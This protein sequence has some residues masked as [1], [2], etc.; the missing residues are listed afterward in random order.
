MKVYHA[1]TK[2][3]FENIKRDGFIQARYPS[4]IVGYKIKDVKNKKLRSFLI[5]ALSC[6]ESKKRVVWLSS[7]GIKLNPFKDEYII[8]IQISEKD[9][10][11]YVKNASSLA[12]ILHQCWGVIFCSKT[13][14][15]N[16]N[17]YLKNMKKSSDGKRIIASASF[18]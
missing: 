16:Q 6:I 13:L 12:G 3:N 18:K 14:Q 17:I 5:K 1:T 4:N 7:K 15:V 8:E 2:E 10:H 11:E 9:V